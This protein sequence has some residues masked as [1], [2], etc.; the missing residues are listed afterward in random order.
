MN[1]KIKS[2]NKKIKYKSGE[3]N[4]N[5]QRARD[6]IHFDNHAK[7]W[8]FCSKDYRNDNPCEC[9]VLDGVKCEHIKN[10]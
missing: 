6:C 5:G 9:I 10:G 4:C 3:M 8:G 1:N 7:E 2:F